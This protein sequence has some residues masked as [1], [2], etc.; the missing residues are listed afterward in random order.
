MN[1]NCVNSQ[2]NQTD[3]RWGV[4]QTCDTSGSRQNLEKN[5]ECETSGLP[6]ACNGN[7]I[8]YP[9]QGKQCASLAQCPVGSFCNYGGTLN[10]SKRQKGVFG[11]TPNVCQIVSPLRFTYKDTVYYYNSEKDLKSWCR[12]ANNKPNCKWG[13]LAKPGAESWCASLGKRLLTKAEIADVWSE[14]RQVLPKTYTG[15]AY[16]ISEGVWLENQTGKI[17]F[18]KGRPDGYGGRGGVVCK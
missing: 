17:G 3:C 6:G 16:W 8:C 18:I 1:K 11:Q 15:Y 7:G 10:S 13:Y 2:D 9:T 4:C 12:A 14:L 5:A